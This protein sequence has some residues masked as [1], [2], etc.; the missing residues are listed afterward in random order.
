MNGDN[1]KIE[2]SKKLINPFVKLFPSHAE[3]AAGYFT[4][5]SRDANGN[6]EHKPVLDA[7]GNVVPVGFDKD[8]GK[9]QMRVR[10]LRTV[11]GN[12]TFD[13]IIMSRARVDISIPNED[14]NSNLRK[15]NIT[16]PITFLEEKNSK[17][18]VLT[19]KSE[20]YRD[21]IKVNVP[22][23]PYIIGADGSKIAVQTE[24]RDYYDRESGVV[25]KKLMAPVGFDSN[26]Q[27]VWDDGRK[28]I[29]K[30]GSPRVAEFEAR[31]ISYATFKTAVK[32]EY[33]SEIMSLD[34]LKAVMTMGLTDKDLDDHYDRVGKKANERLDRIYDVFKSK[35]V[36]YY[37]AD[38]P[39]TPEDVKALVTEKQLKDKPVELKR[40]G[41]FDTIEI[42]S[43]NVYKTNISGRD[44]LLVYLPSD[45]IVGDGK[46]ISEDDLPMAKNLKLDLYI[47][48]D[49]SQYKDGKL[50]YDKRDNIQI[51][52]TLN[53][54]YGYHV[55]DGLVG[56]E[57]SMEHLLDSCFE[58]ADRDNAWST[59]IGY[60]TSPY[61]D[62]FCKDC[63]N[64]V[65]KDI[66]VY[67]SQAVSDSSTDNEHL[68]HNQTLV[69][70][71]DITG[72]GS[73]YV[74]VSDH[75][76]VYGDDFDLTLD[77]VGDDGPVPDDDLKAH[78]E[79]LLKRYPD[80]EEFINPKRI[81]KPHK[82]KPE[83]DIPGIDIPGIDIPEPP[84]EGPE[85][86]F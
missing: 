24:V 22:T 52:Y 16:V 58:K 69:E 74:G 17:T 71:E 10:D 1:I 66:L 4:I 42:S 61:S 84:D 13:E 38:H 64:S 43:E 85:I 35:A 6:I 41:Y 63:A 31:G 33:K 51:K 46:F 80:Y 39:V 73:K 3:Q 70:F 79:D 83:I 67:N 48:V 77:G 34:E 76:V 37:D 27:P 68:Y 57:I 20:A 45:T 7:D 25:S 18:S 32:Y 47:D 55:G 81:K 26:N 36:H 49:P 9:P 72:F 86:D 15:R 11:E 44:R 40:T 65:N 2:F 19:L 59:I 78:H 23:T 21:G 54:K 8:T 14:P 28:A 56:S 82:D 30:E 62:E 75:F 29:F 5:S 60:Y 12:C 53:D 50:I